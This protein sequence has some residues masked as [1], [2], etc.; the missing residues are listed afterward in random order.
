MFC[1]IYV[2][3]P[4][5]TRNSLWLQLHKVETYTMLFGCFADDVFA[6]I[7]KCSDAVPLFAFSLQAVIKTF[8]PISSF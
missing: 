7:T 2:A 8:R 6:I 4:D 5:D 1:Q 3:T